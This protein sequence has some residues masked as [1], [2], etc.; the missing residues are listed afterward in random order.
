MRYVL[1]VLIFLTVILVLLL[2]QTPRKTPGRKPSSTAQNKKTSIKDVS[3]DEVAT[4]FKMY[5]I[6][7]NLTV[8]LFRELS[9]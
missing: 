3:D 4:V 6:V 2:K 9:F 7:N 1:R 5:F 8:F